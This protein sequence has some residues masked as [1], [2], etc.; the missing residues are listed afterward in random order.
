MFPKAMPALESVMGSVGLGVL[1]ALSEGQRAI[2]HLAVLL[3]VP[4]AV[5]LVF[6][7]RRV[8]R[9]DVSGEREREQED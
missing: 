2:T 3:A 9:R 7:V 8:R 1:A 6:L 5:G 4:V